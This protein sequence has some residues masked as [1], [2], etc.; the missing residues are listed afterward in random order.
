MKWK[1][2]VF[3][4]GMAGICS[5]SHA[6]A[7]RYLDYA[8]KLDAQQDITAAPL[9]GYAWDHSYCLRYQVNHPNLLILGDSIFDGWS[10]YL[11][12]VFPSAF[13]DARVGR[14]FS[15]G[16]LDY[17]S[18]LQYKG[19]QQIPVVVLELGTNGPVT[20]QQVQEFMALAGNRS[21]YWITPSVPRPWQ[22]EV[23]SVAHW[24]KGRYPN[25]HLVS[26]HH[27]AS[28]H[29]NWFWGDQVHPNWY[30]IQHLVGLLKDSLEGNGK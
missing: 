11:L 6:F 12:H 30:G 13:I 21:V 17:K 26:W 1:I 9:S 18:L 22:Q 14:Q 27:L 5:F 3:L 10:G 29:P 24:S 19:V 25:I 2:A 16:V 15:A 7:E 8:A 28:G 20:K 4:A 23:L